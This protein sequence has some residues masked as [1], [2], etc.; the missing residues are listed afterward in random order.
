MFFLWDE[1]EH[2]EHS[3]CFM[4][5]YNDDRVTDVS[6]CKYFTRIRLFS[7]KKNVP[8]IFPA[9]GAVLRGRRVTAIPS[10]AA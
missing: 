5:Q 1:L 9:D 3:E 7:A 4:L 8:T 10:T 2:G 6:V